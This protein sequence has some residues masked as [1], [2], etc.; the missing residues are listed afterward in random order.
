MVIYFRSRKIRYF[1]LF[2]LFLKIVEATDSTSFDP[3]VILPKTMHCFFFFF[4][5]CKNGGLVKKCLFVGICEKLENFSQNQN[6][7]SCLLEEMSD[8][9]T[10][11]K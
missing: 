4:F 3:V 1:Q 10:S 6:G 5:F 9:V 7:H 2:C 11:L 8:K